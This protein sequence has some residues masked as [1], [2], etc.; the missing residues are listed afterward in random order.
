MHSVEQPSN[1]KIKETVKLHQ[2][3][4]REESGLYICEG[5]KIFQELISSKTEIKE[6]FTTKD[7]DK[8]L[9]CPV[10]KVTEDVMKKIS[11]T[12]S[13]CEVLAVV[14]KTETDIKKFQTS[15]KI[16]LLDSVSDPGNLGT[17]IRS[18]AAFNIDGIILYGN[19]VDLYSSKVIR[20]S[21]G[22][23]FKTPIISVKSKEELIKLFPNHQIVATA[24]SKKNNI[25]INEC[26]HFNKYI[27]M[28]GS[29]ATGLSQELIE[30]ADKNIKLQ[31]A[32]NVESLNISVSVS[33]ILYELYLSS[34]V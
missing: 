29:E 14:K 5:N 18:A 25:S 34:K 20:S 24:L 22:N 7:I 30:I 32:K 11:T 16:I 28:F 12:D 31:M 9:N 23:Y 1:N 10:Y 13:P 2:K 4:Y 19:C 6:V 3:K 27:I 21:A 8:T 33:I 15:K 17:I 26:A